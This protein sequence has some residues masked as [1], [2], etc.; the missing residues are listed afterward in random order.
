M[1]VVAL[2]VPK[3]G[4]RFQEIVCGLCNVRLRYSPHDIHGTIIRCPDCAGANVVDL[5][6]IWLVWVAK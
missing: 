5:T 1:A 3:V 6:R 4:S 2:R